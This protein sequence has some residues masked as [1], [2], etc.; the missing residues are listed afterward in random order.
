MGC[1]DALAGIGNAAALEGLAGIAGD[2]AVDVGLRSLA[3]GRLGTC[4]EKALPHL[5]PLVFDETQTGHGINDHKL[6]LCDD[7]AEAIDDILLHRFRWQHS[8]GYDDRRGPAL[9]AIRA[10]AKK[11]GYGP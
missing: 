6:R 1:L 7:A 9:E 4:G 2:T 11:R 8:V 10:E 5:W 3:I